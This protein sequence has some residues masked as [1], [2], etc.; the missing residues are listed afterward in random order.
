M[1]LFSL[2]LGGWWNPSCH[3]SHA[4]SVDYCQRSLLLTGPFF[5]SDPPVHNRDMLYL[6]QRRWWILNKECDAPFPYSLE[7]TTCNR[8]GRAEI[9]SVTGMIFLYYNYTLLTIRPYVEFE[10]TNRDNLQLFAICTCT[11]IIFPKIIVN[12]AI[13]IWQGC[14]ARSIGYLRNYVIMPTS[15]VAVGSYNRCL[16]PSVHFIFASLSTVTSHLQIK[17]FFFEH[18]M[19]SKKC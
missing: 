17:I 19:T 14:S 8:R 15:H 10:V 7:N 3:H 18:K 2:S 9:V 4:D 11:C 16:K 12:I 6:A 1:F 13:K 5:F